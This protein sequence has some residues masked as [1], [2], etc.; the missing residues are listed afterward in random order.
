MVCDAVATAALAFFNPHEAH[1]W[2]HAIAS[3]FGIS[4]FF[5]TSRSG[6]LLTNENP[7]SLSSL[8]PPP[9]LSLSTPHEIPSDIR[10]K[11]MF[12]LQKEVAVT[13]KEGVALTLRTARI[14]SLSPP[15]LSFLV[16]DS[17]S[18]PQR[19]SFSLPTHSEGW[20]CCVTHR[21]GPL[22]I[23]S[24]EIEGDSSVMLLRNLRRDMDVP[25]RCTVK[26]FPQIKQ[27]DG[28]DPVVLPI[29]TSLAIAGRYISL[30]VENNSVFG[31]AIATARENDILEISA[32]EDSFQ[33][34]II[35]SHLCGD[36]YVL[37]SSP[38]PISLADTS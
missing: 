6:V 11:S 9:S 34:T 20:N 24:I 32:N 2:L 5:L 1:F 15:L 4:R 19:F 28:G 25:F 14:V 26:Y 21:N 37:L 16:D 27:S 18:L 8:P 23:S 31:M 7:P 29:C 12:S 38:L 13:S 22:V 35:Q 17:Q 10:M 30:N 3:E 36:H 33:T